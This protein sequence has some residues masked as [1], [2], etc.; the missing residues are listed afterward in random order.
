MSNTRTITQGDHV[1]G[2]QRLDV[3]TDLGGPAVDNISAA[4]RAARLVTQLPSKD[5]RGVPVPRDN[6]LDIGLVHALDLLVG[7]PLSLAAAVGLDIGVVSAVV[8]PAVHERNDELDAVLLSGS[9]HIVKTLETVF[10]GVDGGSALLLVVEL[11]VDRSGAGSG[12]NIVEAP[13]TKDLQSGL[14][15]MIEHGVN[16]RIVHLEG[17]PV[18]I[19]AGEVLGLAVNRELQS[20][21]LGEGPAARGTRAWRGRRRRRQG[22]GFRR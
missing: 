11:E 22:S 13:D 4:S 10:A 18:G 2:I 17:E 6:S 3:G 14:L 5:R 7:E 21:R 20:I 16:V 1:V 15:Q 9:N 8:V 19:C 12:V